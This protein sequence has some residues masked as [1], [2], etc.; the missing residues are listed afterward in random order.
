MG[1]VALGVSLWRD[2]VYR[3]NPKN[4]LWFGRDRFVLSVGH[5]CV[6]QYNMLH[7]SG[8]ERFTLDEVKRYHAPDFVGSLANGHPEI[9]QEA[10][11]EMT[12]GL[13]GQGIANAV[14]LAIA[15][16]NIEARY[17]RPGFE[18]LFNTKIWCMIGDG[19]IQEGLGQEAI[20][21][22]GHLGLDN[23]VVL[24]DKNAITWVTWH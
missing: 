16:K 22:A 7:F 8:Y 20:S 12:T 19:C 3:F 11:I 21:I 6:F 5:A 23:L 18:N 14:G 9:D 15:S 4:P 24:Y 13:L 1:A 17:T 2:G 10:G